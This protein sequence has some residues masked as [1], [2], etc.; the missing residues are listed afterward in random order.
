MP[1]RQ[2]LAVV[3]TLVVLS[4]FGVARGLAQE[5][6]ADVIAR[7]EQAVVRIEVE[8]NQGRSLGSGFLVDASGTLV[9]NTH[10]L[11][12]AL[13]AVA[14]FPNGQ[15][16]EIKGTLRIDPPYDICVA[17]ID[18][19]GFSFLTLAGELPRKGE[20]VTAL[21]SPKG[22]SFSATT[23][24]VSAIRPAAELGPEIGRPEIRGTWIQVDAALSGGNSGGPLINDRGEVVGMSTLASQGSAQNLNF[25]ISAAD[26]RGA[27]ENSRSVGLISLA[28]GAAKLEMAERP[29]SGTIIERP[30]IPNDKLK[31]YV[32]DG[33][34]EFNDLLRGLR[35]ELSRESDTLREMRKGEAYL[36]PGSP[37]SAEIVRLIIPKSKNKRFYFRNQ[38][39]KDRE[40]SSLQKRVRELEAIRDSTA[41]VDDK[42]SLYS[43]LSKYGPRLDP[44]RNGSVGFMLDAIVL[45]PFNEHDVIILLEEAP[46]LLWLESTTGLSE[47][48]RLTPQPVYV[49]GTKTIQV[50]GQ[51]PRAATVLHAVTDAELREALFGS[52]TAGSGQWRFWKDS[53]GQYQVEATLVDVTSTAVVLKKRDGTTLSVPLDRLSKEDLEFLG[54]K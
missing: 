45:H 43:L 50:P 54:K 39:V 5:S 41:S 49:A 33:R 25:G 8:G 48:T 21:G 35:S 37:A 23:G 51:V 30:P 24:I 53:T 9:T 46:C 3:L 20:R 44:R 18:G 26:I 40:I 6:L 13:K 47:G 7:C 42:N 10:V 15:A 17:K 34:L 19:T 4:Q 12:G 22:L 16:H 36:P 1:S 52:T 2:Q 27:V 14:I 11:A 32:E 31:Q 29:E 38:T 28:D